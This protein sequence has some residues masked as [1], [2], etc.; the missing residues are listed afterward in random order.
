MSGK[1][2]ITRMLNPIRKKKKSAKVKRRKGARQ[3][4]VRSLGGKWVIRRIGVNRSA[5][6]WTGNI[7]APIRSHA[8]KFSSDSA[9]A[10]AL[11]AARAKGGKDWVVMDVMPA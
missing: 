9:A 8:K 1:L 6:W 11:P 5:S 2:K 4:K 3:R 7:W 10:R